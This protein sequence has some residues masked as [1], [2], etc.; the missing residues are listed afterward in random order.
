[1]QTLADLHNATPK[2]NGVTN[3]HTGVTT[4]ENNTV[5]ESEVMDSNEARAHAEAEK[6]D[7][8]Y[9]AVSMFPALLEAMRANAG[10]KPLGTYAQ[11]LI[12]DALGVTIP[13]SLRTRTKYASEEDKKAAAKKAAQVRG[14]LVKYLMAEHRVRL[15]YE[16]NTKPSEKDITII[17]AGRAAGFPAAFEL[18]A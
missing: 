10:N 9:V 6:K 11:S 17:R 16:E 5:E 3:Q 8:K 13:S 1:M 4:V 12:A 2:Y 14:A 15:A 18:Q 7:P